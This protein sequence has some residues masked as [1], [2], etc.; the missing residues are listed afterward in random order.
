MNLRTKY[1]VFVAILH[2]TALL[3]TYFIFKTDRIFFIASEIVILISLVLSWQLYKDLIA[4][5]KLLTQGTEA[6][7]DRDF[8]V[9][10]VP[11]G[12]YEI[13][14]LIDVYNRMMDELRSER[15]KQE[16]QH[17]F[18]EKLIQT[19][20]TGIV[21]LDF[22]ENIQ[23]INPKALDILALKKSYILGKNIHEVSHPLIG[24]ITAMNSGES[25][26]LTIDGTATYKIQKSHFID[27]GFP[28][29]FVMIEELT[30]E[31][32]AAEKKAYGKV[33]RIM[34]HEVNNSL[35][36]VNS[37]IQTT[38]ASKKIWSDEQHNDLKHALEIA[39]Q[40]NY[41]LN[42]FMRN[43]ADLVRLPAPEL[44]II[45]L[46]NI[47]QHVVALMQQ[48]GGEKKIDFVWVKNEL[49]F[50]IQ[51]DEQ[52]LQHVLINIINNAIEAIDNNGTIAIETDPIARTLKITDNG[53]GITEEQSA[54][55]FSPFYSS[56]KDGQGIGLT[57]NKEI[58]VNHGF[59][60]SLKTVAPGRTEFTIKF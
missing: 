56:K 1:I 3:L 4:P 53:R 58:L 2:F 36:A 17:L 9:K 20:P 27:R 32:L 29:F 45:D 47:I 13:D 15:T 11:T 55:L 5:L 54:Q 14:Q 25:R 39:V 23:Q 59:G 28:R 7:R 48:K 10:F 6:I 52:Q 41:N 46:H 33:I 30:A 35:G 12:K 40:R 31:I 42:I 21:I 24:L 37:I 43:F 22:D 49:P 26:P 57:L 8:N 44:K 60:F 34:A 19:S 16:Q 18:L 38:L 50:A 51:A